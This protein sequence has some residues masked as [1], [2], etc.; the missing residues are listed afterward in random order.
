MFVILE[1]AAKNDTTSRIFISYE[2]EMKLI[3]RSDSGD[4]PAEF[5]NY[6]MATDFESGRSAKGV[7]LFLVAHSAA[8][9]LKLQ[10]GK[11]SSPKIE[12]AIAPALF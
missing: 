1:V 4:N 9:N 5:Y 12:T 8:Y 11:A 10:F 6:W 2:E 7:F 3:V